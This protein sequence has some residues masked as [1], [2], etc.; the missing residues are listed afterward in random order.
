MKPFPIQTLIEA[1]LDSIVEAAGGMR[2]HPDAD[3]RDKVGADYVLGQTVIELKI[4]DE[5]GFDKPTRQAKLAELFR[6]HQPDRP[7]VVVDPELLP[8]GDRRRYRNI[9]E[10]PIKRVIAKSKQQLEQSREEFNETTGSVL[11]IVNN[12]YTALDHDML[13]ELAANRVRQDTSGID[14]IIVSGCY[15]HSDGFDSVFLWPCDYVP[16][17]LDHR[18]PEFDRLHDEFQAFAE[19]FMTNLMRQ[20]Q[21]AGDKFEV[22]DLVF[23]VNGVRFVRPAPV[24][25]QPSEFYVGG[26]PRANSSGIEE[27]PPVG[28]IVPGLKRADHELIS[29]V[30][31][32]PGGPLGN[33]PAWQ[34]HLEGAAAAANP[35]KPL[36]SIPVDPEEWLRWCKAEGERPSLRALSH[37]AH[38]IFEERIRAILNSARER[39]E[40]GIIPSAYVLAVTQEIGQ[41]RAND[42]S[43]IAAVRERATDGPIIR[44]L[45]ENLRIFHEHAVALA[46]A[47]TLR[48]GLDLVLWSRNSRHG[49]I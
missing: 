12:G 35:K 41:D 2:A 21:P 17:R 20:A 4:L 11:W 5:E 43:D 33:W 1:D 40:G 39:S 23:D 31:G 29:G 15:Y 13:E 6:A 27:C 19:T 24:M 36:I 47:Y 9:V 14:G 32:E 49:W 18:F 26:R 42:V 10:Q 7:V 22:R 44:P 30:I 8:D 28:L 48:E 25:G 38:T 34:H 16:T 45:A 3:R 46:A 37:F